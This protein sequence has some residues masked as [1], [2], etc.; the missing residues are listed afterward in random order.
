MEYKGDTDMYSEQ[1][2]MRSG[3]AVTARAEEE[4]GAIIAKAQLPAGSGCE[5]TKDEMY[6]LMLSA[7]RQDYGDK[8]S[9]EL[10]KHMLLYWAVRVN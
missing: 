3:A 7:I 5:P 9:K 6:R 10:S 8:V 4:L 1:H 2:Y